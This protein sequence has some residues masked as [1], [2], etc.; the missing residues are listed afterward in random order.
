MNIDQLLYLTGT[1]LPSKAKYAFSEKSYPTLLNILPDE[2]MQELQKLDSSRDI[3]LI[4]KF[5]HDVEAKSFNHPF[6]VINPDEEI[7]IM[8]NYN[9]RYEEYAEYKIVDGNVICLISESIYSRKS[10][11]HYIIR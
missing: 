8:Y 9:F 4:A 6:N 2:L 7:K 11:S 10:Y 5:L 1:Q 3:K